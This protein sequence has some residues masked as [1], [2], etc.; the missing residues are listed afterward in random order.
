M[1]FQA[2]TPPPLKR[3]PNEKNSPLAKKKNMA[4][5]ISVIIIEMFLSS[6]Y[7]HFFIRIFG[8][9]PVVLP[10]DGSEQAKRKTTFYNFSVSGKGNLSLKWFDMLKNQGLYNFEQ[11]LWPFL[12]GHIASPY[13]FW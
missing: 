4:T 10:D 13:S 11:L 9:F 2:I 8:K 7:F 6:H 3:K 12:E 5:F 1:I